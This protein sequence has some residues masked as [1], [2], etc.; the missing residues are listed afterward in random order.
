M[1]RDESRYEAHDCEVNKLAGMEKKKKKKDSS[2]LQVSIEK[3]PTYVP[4]YYS[5]VFLWWGK[6]IVANACSL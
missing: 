4:K 2:V 6:C 3:L 1:D 5:T